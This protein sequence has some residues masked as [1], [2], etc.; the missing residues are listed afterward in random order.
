MKYYNYILYIYIYI[1]NEFDNL[2]PLFYLFELD[3]W[4]YWTVHYA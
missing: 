4:L 2:F 3:W 1:L